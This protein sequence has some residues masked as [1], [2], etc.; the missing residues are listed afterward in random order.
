MTSKLFP[1][2]SYKMRGCATFALGGLDSASSVWVPCTIHGKHGSIALLEMAVI[3]NRSDEESV[4][5][6]NS[7]KLWELTFCYHTSSQ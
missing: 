6:S 4:A 3:F 5:G 1:S 2:G 7:M